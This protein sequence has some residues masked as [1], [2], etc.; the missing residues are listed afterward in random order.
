MALKLREIRLSGRL[1][2]ADDPTTIAPEDFSVLT[3]LAYGNNNPIAI[4]GQTKINTTAL[5]G[6][7]TNAIQ[8][9]KDQPSESIIIAHQGTS[10]YQHK[11]AVPATGNFETT[12]LK[13]GIGSSVRWSE[14][15]ADSLVICD[16]SDTLIYPGDEM[17]ISAFFDVDDV[18]DTYEY[19]YTDVLLNS[20]TGSDQVATIHNESG[21][22]V[23]IVMSRLP[24]VGVWFT[25]STVNET[26]GTITAGQYWGGSP[27]QWATLG[28]ITRK[29][30]SGDA[31]SD[32]IPFSQAKE[33]WEFDVPNTYLHALKSIKGKIFY[34]YRFVISNVDATTKLSNVSLQ[35]EVGAIKDL[36]DGTYQQEAGVLHFDGSSTYTDYT[37]NCFDDSYD[38]SDATTYMV[39][40]LTSSKEVIV[41]SPVRL[42]GLVF[43]LPSDLVNAVTATMTAKYYNGSDVPTASGAW[44]ALTIDDG[45]D[46][47]GASLGQSGIV[48]W[49][50]PADNVEFLTYM[51][52][53]KR[54]SS[55]N[56]ILVENEI[57]QFY[58]YK[59]TVNATL[60]ST[61]R[62]YYISGIPA[63][64]TIRNF[65][66]PVSHLSRL[67][68]CNMLD[69]EPNAVICSA[70]ET[71]QIFSGDDTA[72]YN[73]GG[74]EGLVAGASLYGRYGAGTYSVL[75]LC[76][77]G[78]TW[79]IT[80]ET[81]D[82]L[83]VFKISDH[84]G[85]IAPHTMKSAG[86]GTQEAVSRNYVLWLSN[87]GPVKFDGSSIV[88]IG[89]D[90]QDLFDP[91]KSTYLGKSVLSAAT[92]FV[93]SER[94]R[95]HLCF[96]TSGE[97]AY[98]LV[99]S[100]WFE[101]DR[102]SGAYITG[103]LSV[104]DSNGIAYPY[105]FDSSGYLFRLENGTTFN[106][107]DIA[108]TFKTGD[109][110]LKDNYIDIE[111]TFRG[112]KLV[113]KAKS[114]TANSV[115]LT[116]FGNSATSGKTIATIS[117]VASGKRVSDVTE[118]KRLGPHIFHSI[119]G[120]LSTDDET[121][122]F[123]PIMLGILYEPVRIDTR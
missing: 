73:I 54:P 58:Y 56:L 3:N 19:D 116:H 104:K 103:G 47:G 48:T 12:A 88:P 120:S 2:T 18:T 111:T 87:T 94:N 39:P 79:A 59:I 38:S 42:M 8:F 110:S 61:A 66:F 75:V 62:I 35:G 37:S 26:A 105:G 109:I 67:W 80:G 33:L 78:Q 34:A 32:G 82:N 4:G 45:T 119:Q 100:K 1:R 101:I 52:T 7:I 117:P 84:I 25:V 108:C 76:K 11:S 41:A 114:N 107:N 92:S 10:L 70:S 21:T 30:T 112:I 24:V 23:L 6:A 85:C 44:T 95:W 31:I 5:G 115:T 65:K 71:S 90:I 36:W 16:G 28:G 122:G 22:T 106:G 63:P 13:T 46:S 14:A 29:D 40:A 81:L 49:A 86:I 83:S 51:K 97:W 74:P 102:G 89:G 121:I 77:Y 60:T 98:D 57:Q 43:K 64:Q 96:G 55:R 68:L 113:Q 69:E 99:R 118:T 72:K 123:E 93:D 91:Q 20:D 27:A 17:K 50:P 53:G 15:P 9:I